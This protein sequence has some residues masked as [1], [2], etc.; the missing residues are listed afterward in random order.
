M[1]YSTRCKL[2]TVA[3]GC[4]VA[5]AI[6]LIV[7]FTMKGAGAPT[8]ETENRLP[9]TVVP[10]RYDIL[11]HPD[12]DEKAPTF[13]NFTGTVGIR[14]EFREDRTW[15]VVHAKYLDITKVSLKSDDGSVIELAAPIE[16]PQNEWWVIQPAKGSIPRGTHT[17]TVDFKGRLDRSIV[18]FYRSV[19]TNAKGES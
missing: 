6:A 17:F 19:H 3:A 2:A 14:I 1:A 10:S 15:F 8:W 7:V 12:L 13:G 9:D 5:I 4:L 11:L 16:I 18:G